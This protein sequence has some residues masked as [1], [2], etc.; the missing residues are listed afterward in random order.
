MNSLRKTVSEKTGTTIPADDIRNAT[1]SETGVDDIVEP[2]D[3]NSSEYPAKVVGDRVYLTPAGP[4]FAED[5]LRFLSDY[6]IAKTLT[7][8]AKNY[9]PETEAKALAN[10]ASDP[11][12]YMFAVVEKGSDKVIG[13][14]SLFG[15]D[16]ISALAELGI[17]IG[18]RDYLGKG[19]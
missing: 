15:I 2:F 7:T 17:M 11:G 6:E 19:F 5:F 9:V 1:E 16:R 12:H 10:I 3:R 18:D 8:F 13:A 4:A 14:V